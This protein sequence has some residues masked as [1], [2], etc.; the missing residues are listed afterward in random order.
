M[1]IGLF[2]QAYCDIWFD[3]QAYQSKERHTVRDWANLKNADLCFNLGLFDTKTGDGY[4]YV[5]N[6]DGD[7]GYGGKSDD[8]RINEFNVCRGYTNAIKWGNVNI[9]NPLSPPTYDPK[10][11]RKVYPTA[12]R[13]GIGI[14]TDGLIILA[15]TKVA[16]TESTFANAVNDWVT[17][18]K[19]GK[20]VKLFVLQDGGGS[21]SE[22]SAR[23]K[24]GFYATGERR[25]VATVTC[26]R[27]RD[28]P[29]VERTLRLFCKG[30]DVKI[31]QIVL[32]GV[33]VDGSFGPET[34]KRLKEVQKALGLKAD[35]SCGPLTRAA[36]GI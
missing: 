33:E 32:G 34:Y 6:K 7:F 21:T 13:N 9:E 1:N 30:E 17:D 4:T 12:I 26:I 20:T 27:F 28:L 8:L 35:G 24:S 22:Y 31:L 2:N 29:K 5:R 23:G 15:Q 14:T 3:G 36:L 11:K 25:P 10:K 19:R 16:V 18:K